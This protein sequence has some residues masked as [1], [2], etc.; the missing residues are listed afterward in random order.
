MANGNGTANFYLKVIGVLLSVILFVAMGTAVSRNN[1]DHSEI[2]TSLTTKA[3]QEDLVR[4]E[5]SVIKL[6]DKIQ[7]FIEHAPPRHVH[8][9]DKGGVT[10]VVP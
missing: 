4:L 3:D 9:D 5:K 7:L 1:Q 2:K 10:R 8:I 6:V